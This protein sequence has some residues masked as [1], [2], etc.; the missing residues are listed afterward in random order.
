M[1]KALAALAVGLMA[2]S[3]GAYAKDWKEIR[4]GVDASYAPFEYKAPNGQ[5]VGFDIDLGNEICKRM[6]AK[7]VW[8]ENDFDGM[9]P[10]LKAKKFDGVLSSMSMT[11][12]R[13]KEIAFSAKL[14]NTPTR[15]V[16]KAGSGLMP[17]PASLKGKR[18]G[19]EQGTIQEAYAKKHWAPAGVEVVPYQNQTLVLADLTAG[20]LD[21]SL[22]DAVQADIGFLKKPEGKGFA[23]AGKDLVDPQTLG[24]GAGIGLRKEDKD[25]KAGIDKAIADMLKDGTYKKIEK[26]YFTFDVYGG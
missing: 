4:F 6:K 2:A 23:F 25:L 7:C 20:R 9:I 8:V 1:K 3:L 14:F 10:A 21:A 17:T 12:A 13:M 19:V 11:E 26:K 18:V 24:E 5:V 16:A 22:Q 15:M